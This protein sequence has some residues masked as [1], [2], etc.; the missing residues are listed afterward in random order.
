MNIHEV[1][2]N[3]ICSNLFYIVVKYISICIITDYK[4]T[5]YWIEKSTTKAIALVDKTKYILQRQIVRIVG[6]QIE[7]LVCAKDAIT[8]FHSIYGCSYMSMLPHTGLD[9]HTTGHCIVMLGSV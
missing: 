4:Y 6:K 5:S 9:N 8:S 1:S 3:G 7:Y 2:C